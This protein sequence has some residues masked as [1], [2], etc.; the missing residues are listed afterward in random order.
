VDPDEIHRSG[1]GFTRDEEIVHKEV[2]KV[3]PHRM[4]RDG[5]LRG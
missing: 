4:L 5:I 3:I 1:E 2:Q